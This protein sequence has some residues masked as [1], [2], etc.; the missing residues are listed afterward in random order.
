[1][2][3]YI[4]SFTIKTDSSA[5][6]SFGGCYGYDIRGDFFDK[7]DH[8]CR[9]GFGRNGHTFD[10]DDCL[11]PTKLCPLYQIKDGRKSISLIEEET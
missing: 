9:F 10:G 2:P 7:R 8:T 5:L 3:K 1:M 4:S 6:C 11:E